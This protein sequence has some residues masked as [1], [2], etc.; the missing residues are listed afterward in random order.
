M[1]DFEKILLQAFFSLVAAVFGSLL[2]VWLALRRFYREK[3]WEQKM[4]AYTSIIQALHHMNRDL[5]ISIR[6]EYAHGD[7][8]SDFHKKWRAKHQE[9]WDEIRKQADIGEFLFSSEAVKLLQEVIT[10]S[11]SDPNDMYLDYLERT[12]S[13]VQ[14]CMPAIKVAARKD[15]GLLS[16]L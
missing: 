8:N 2:V 6:A 16:F 3:W 10:N 15:L 13:A 14:K 4:S 1:T 9:A 11:T 7:T 5:E 12:Q